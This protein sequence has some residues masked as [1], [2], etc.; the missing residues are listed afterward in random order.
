MNTNQTYKKI[1]QY[2]LNQGADTPKS[3]TIKSRFYQWKKQGMLAYVRKGVY[4]PTDLH[5]KFRI[6]C[7]AVEDGC[8][9]YHAALEYYM[10]QTQEFNS[11]YIHSPSTFRPF[12]YLNQSYIYKPVKF[13]HKPII[14]DKK[15]P[16]PIR[17]TS[18]SQTVIDCLYNI[19]LAGGLEELLY[20][21]SDIAPETINEKDML[22]CLKLYNSKSLYQRAGYILSCFKESLQLSDAF[23]MSC[24]SSIGSNVSYLINPYHCNSFSKEW[25]LCIPYNIMKQI[26]KDS[27]YEV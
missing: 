2:Q 14:I 13:L 1:E 26:Q 18:L 21:L 3:S 25:N 15:E 24:K 5:D 22:H 17:V 10:L 19:N 27:I 12:T 9:V 6:A 4:L 16:Y 23:F 7:N 8:L 11:L 20:A